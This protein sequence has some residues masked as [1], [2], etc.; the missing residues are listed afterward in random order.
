MSLICSY[1]EKGCTH[2]NE[3]SIRPSDETL[4]ILRMAASVLHNLVKAMN[5]SLVKM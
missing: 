4:Q 2:I 5:E 3:V 1:V